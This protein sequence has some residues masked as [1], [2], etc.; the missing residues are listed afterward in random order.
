MIRNGSGAHGPALTSKVWAA[1]LFLAASLT[2]GGC[3]L[4]TKAWAEGELS[5]LPGQSLSIFDPWLD[6]ALA[7][8][9]GAAF[10]IVGDLGT[11][12]AVLGIVSFVLAAGLLLMV[13]LS[14]RVTRLEALALGAIAAG[15]IGNGYDRLFRLA[16]GGG[17][18]VVD[19]IRVNYPWGGSWPTFNV[20]DMLV[21]VGVAVLALTYLWPKRPQAGAGEA[22][23]TASQ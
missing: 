3:D 15:A 22:K 18:G 14:R 21:F 17:T 2:G 10:S 12:R 23:A 1:A 11:T 19:F 7:Y 6:F 16:P 5:S 4:T 8:N 9:Q 20:A 13:V